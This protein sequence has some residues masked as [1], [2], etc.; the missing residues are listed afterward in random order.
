MK[1]ETKERKDFGWTKLT[2]EK[3]EIPEKAKEAL[4]RKFDK[5]IQDDPTVSKAVKSLFTTSEDA[6]KQPAQHWVTHNPLYY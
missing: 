3:S 5:S 4:K 1:A 6:K 2:G